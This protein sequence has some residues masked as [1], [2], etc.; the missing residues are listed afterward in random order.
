MSTAI[1]S[2]RI[3]PVIL[4]FLL[5]AANLYLA[6]ISWPDSNCLKYALFSIIYLSLDA[7]FLFNVKFSELI[8]FIIISLIL[9]LYPV[10]IDFKDLHPWSAG[11]LSAINVTLLVIC[12]VLLLLKIKD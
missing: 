10:I 11:A 5:F 3:S 4:I 12:F 1:R 8:V 2:I 7:L 6:I 9:F